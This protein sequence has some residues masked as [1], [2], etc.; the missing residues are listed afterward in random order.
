MLI[1]ILNG[2]HLNQFHDSSEFFLFINRYCSGIRHQRI[3]PRVYIIRFKFQERSVSQ[4][5]SNPIGIFCLKDRV[6]YL[7]V[8]LSPRR[9]DTRSEMSRQLSRLFSDLGNFARTHVWDN[10][11]VLINTYY[12]SHF[13]LYVSRSGTWF[14]LF[15]FTPSFHIFLPSEFISLSIFSSDFTY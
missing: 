11:L 15:L 4:V 6:P 13:D 7:G 5:F 8:Q 3:Q 9:D 1:V 14:I 2:G 12:F 10:A